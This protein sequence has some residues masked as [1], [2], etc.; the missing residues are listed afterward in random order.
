MVPNH[1]VESFCHA[2]PH[3]EREDRGPLHGPR[4]RGHGGH[5]RGAGQ[6]QVS[7]LAMKAM[8]RKSDAHVFSNIFSQWLT[9]LVSGNQEIA[10]DLG[11][12]TT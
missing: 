9:L 12:F 3:D 5:P 8:A 4:R 2:G 11:R 7:L 6:S 10:L 1:H